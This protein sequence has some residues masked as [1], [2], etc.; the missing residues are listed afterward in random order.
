MLEV[1]G[2][3]WRLLGLLGYEQLLWT[4]RLVGECQGLW[5]AAITTGGCRGILGL[6]ILT[7]LTEP[8]GT[9]QVTTALMAAPPL[10]MTMART[11]RRAR[12]WVR[13]GDSCGTP[14]SR[15]LHGA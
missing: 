13:P 4:L 1:L 8:W 10:P 5:G 3:Y 11:T 2:G 9:L 7:L 12:T 15:V 6:G 14:K